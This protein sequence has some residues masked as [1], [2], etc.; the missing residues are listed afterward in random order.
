MVMTTF[1]RQCPSWA[2]LSALAGLL[3]RVGSADDGRQLAGFDDVLE[4][5]KVLV[6]LSRGQ[7][8]QSLTDQ[9]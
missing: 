8:A 7:G 2:S 4:E 5:Q 9:R 3:Q 1:P 6:A